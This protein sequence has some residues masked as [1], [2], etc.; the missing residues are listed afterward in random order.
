VERQ[1]SSH[2][3]ALIVEILTQDPQARPSLQEILAHPWFTTGTM[4]DYIPHSAHDEAPDF[5][6]ISRA[7][8]QSNLARARR[9]ALLDDDQITSIAVPEP[10][11][12]EPSRPA[13]SATAA[14]S[15]GK[16]KTATST[17]AQQE[18][19]FHHAV[20]P[21]SPISALLKSARQPLLVAPS[22]VGKNGKENP[23]LRKLQAAQ[24]ERQPQTAD[25]QPV[26][27]QAI[28]EEDEPE[29]ATKGKRERGADQARKKE[30][31]SQKARIVAQ[32]VPTGPAIDEGARLFGIPL[33][34]ESV[35][36][37]RREGKTKERPDSATGS[38]GSDEPNMKVNSFDAVAATL[39]AA[40]DAKS[41]YRAYK[42]P[43]DNDD[44]PDEQVFIVSWVDYCNKYGMGYALTDGSVG[45]HFNDSTTLVLS[46]DKQC[47]V[48]LFI[49]SSTD[50]I[51]YSHF[52]YVGPRHSGSAYVRKNFTVEEFPPELKNKIYLL[53]HFERYIMNRLYGEYDYTFENLQRTKGM[54]FVQKYLRMK[55]VIVFKMSHD[56]LQFNFYDHSKVVLSHD[57]LRITHID[58]NYKLTR[59]RLADVMAT[60]LRP[61]VADA[62]QAKFDQ[63][64][65][66]KLKYCRDVLISIKNVSETQETD[67]PAAPSARGSERA[68]SRA[69]VR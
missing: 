12:P 36:P 57:G 6:R 40:F 29:V 48:F 50:L 5:S 67:K 56:A 54:S 33:D 34:Q 8:S 1:V 14:I 42:D 24:K 68:T 58:K 35:A 46:P 11:A 25:S 2:V 69:S 9:N 30:L 51:V 7:A 44:L 38:V 45:V 61:P 52:D 53:K 15:N 21:G 28:D 18:K 43:R 26:P 23:L 41:A 19:E 62:E 22:S 60:A 3:R 66:D 31:E 47:V 16:L 55:H 17:L 20:Q 49:T 39:S 4:P 32:M 59:W 65:V 63:R 64:L 27:F 13:S 10:P 37:V